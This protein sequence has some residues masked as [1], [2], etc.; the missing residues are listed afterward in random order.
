MIPDLIKKRNGQVVAFEEDN[1]R[2]NLRKALEASNTEYPVSLLYDLLEVR[3]LFRCKKKT[4]SVEELSDFIEKVMMQEGLHDAARAYILYRFQRKL[5]RE[6]KDVVTKIVDDYVGKTTWRVSENSNITYSYPAMQGAIANNVISNYVLSSI[7]P[8]N[9]SE[10]HLNGDIHIHDLAMGTAGYCAGWDLRTLL[11]EGFGGVSGKLNSRPPSH[12]TSAVDQMINFLG[13]LQNEWAGAMAYNSFDTFLAPYVK[14]DNLDKK[15]VKQCME[16]FIYGVNVT[17]RWGQSPFV[18]VTLDLR[19]PNDLAKDP[20][21]IAGKDMGFLYGDCQTEV[22]LINEA[23]WEVMLE[24]DASSL[25]FTFPNYY[26]N[27]K[28]ESCFVFNEGVYGIVYSCFDSTANV[29]D[30]P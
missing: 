19:I 29:K 24:G 16:N 18:N 15:T 5:F 30:I 10:A 2:T 6:K 17:S 14:I 20:V 9:I 7:Y 11:V 28:P 27:F 3:Y 13:V 25:P 4:I 21:I 23:F 26:I 8:N 22:D 1:I 12:L